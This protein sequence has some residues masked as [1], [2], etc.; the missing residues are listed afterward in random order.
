MV[1]GTTNGTGGVIA[2]WPGS[3]STGKTSRVGSG[4][5]GGGV[6][7]R[8]GTT[9]GVGG[10]GSMAAGVSTTLTESTIIWSLL[11]GAMSMLAIAGDAAAGSPFGT[12]P[13]ASGAGAGGGTS[14]RLSEAASA[15][16]ISW[17]CVSAVT[18]AGVA[19]VIGVSVSCIG[20][21]TGGSYPRAEGG[22]TGGGWEV[23]AAAR[24]VTAGNSPLSNKGRQPSSCE[25]NGSTIFR[26]H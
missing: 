22:L 3:T 26:R 7:S 14:T 23:S 6:G 18:V 2:S 19:S 16:I 9:R 20:G 4:S 8:S 17:S 21:D 13:S 12:E 10:R 25:T 11:E 5:K 1:T 15:S 24:S